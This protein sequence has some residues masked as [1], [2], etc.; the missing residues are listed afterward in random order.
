[1]FSICLISNNESKNIPA[2][3]EEYNHEYRSA[4][5]ERNIPMLLK[6]AMGPPCLC[7]EDGVVA[8]LHGRGTTPTLTLDNDSASVGAKTDGTTP[9]SWFPFPHKRHSILLTSK[10]A[11]HARIAAAPVSTVNAHFFAITRACY[12]ERLEV[13]NLQSKLNESSSRYSGL[14]HIR[15]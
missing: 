12:C 13:P 5:I 14:G 7:L 1:M 3:C 11:S 15:F 10:T 6:L 9:R 2:S 8:H 4:S